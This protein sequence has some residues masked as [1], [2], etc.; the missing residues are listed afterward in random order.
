[1]D[2]DSG[3]EGGK[4]RKGARILEGDEEN[5]VRRMKAKELTCG[6]LGMT[7]DTCNI[8][9]IDEWVLFAGTEGRGEERGEGRGEG[10]G[11]GKGEGSYGRG[12]G[13]GEGRG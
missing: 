13:K 3:K 2:F 1:M 11:R 8:G 4:N 6:L 10:R 12:S 5:V 9:K 7:P